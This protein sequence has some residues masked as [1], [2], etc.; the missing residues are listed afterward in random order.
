MSKKETTQPILVNEDL[1]ALHYF[2]SR[3]PAVQKDVAAMFTAGSIVELKPTQELYD[4]IITSGTAAI[5]ERY[6]SAEKAKVKKFSPTVQANMLEGIELPFKEFEKAVK[7]VLSWSEFDLQGA[8]KFPLDLI[9][10]QDGQAVLTDANIEAIKEQ[11][12]R[13]YVAPGIGVELLQSVQAI[14][15]AHNAFLQVLDKADYLHEY[16]FSSLIDFI[17]IK[18]DKSIEVDA[19]GVNWAAGAKERRDATERRIQK[20]KEH[21]A[22]RNQ[23]VE[24]VSL[25][26]GNVRREGIPGFS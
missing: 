3:F 15:D 7:K 16:D 17:N 13:K 19:S 20:E 22:Q 10:I 12:C 9:T 25:G 23:M 5:F 21:Q 26:A 8:I 6:M 14:A 18:S 24:T 2:T 4:E 1:S 11:F